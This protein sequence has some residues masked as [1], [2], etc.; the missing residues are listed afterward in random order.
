MADERVMLIVD[1][2][3]YTGWTQVQVSRAITQACSA[4]QLSLNDSAELRVDLHPS[5]SCEV[6]CGAET[7]ITGSIDAV[8]ISYT[9]DS[10]DIAISGR[11]RTRDIIDSWL[12]PLQFRGLAVEEI[13]RRIARQFGVELSVIGDA[14]GLQMSSNGFSAVPDQDFAVHARDGLA[15]EA[16][17]DAAGRA[18]WYLSD[19]PEG[20]L[21]LSRTAGAVT[22]NEIIVMPGQ[23]VNALG[24]SYRN[25]E[26]H[27]FN[28]YRVIGQAAP[29]DDSFGLDAA[30]IMAEVTDPDI[31]RNRLKI[32]TAETGLTTVQ[33]QT[34]A[35]QERQAAIAESF[36]IEYIV[37]GWRGSAGALWRE[38]ERVNVRDDIL[39]VRRQ[40]LVDTVNY[41]QDESGGTT[42]RLALVL[43]EA[44][45]PAA[46]STDGV[47]SDADREAA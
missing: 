7:L 38:N 44:R 19:S 2:R 1:G 23:Q 10:H 43:P 34:R 11:S 25:D 36:G 40:L 27:R 32:I 18:G 30:Q 29:T 28:T 31:G 14:T 26:S 24:A 21:V 41:I 33:A 35:I 9:A 3:E 15:F 39:G 42:C 5:Q 6:R 17:Q 46:V 13:V 47:L 4:F 8:E 37:Q 16:I 20:N 22:R 12:D 45:M